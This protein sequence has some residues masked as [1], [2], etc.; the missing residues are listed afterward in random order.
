[1]PP[2]L[3][4]RIDRYRIL[5]FLGRGSMG[6]V[7]L[8]VD[9]KFD[10]RVAL[11][12]MSGH[13]LGEDDEL[14]D[15]RQRF[16][17][18][19]RAAGRLNHPA[20]VT[21]YDADT[22]R[23][24]G[25]PF[26]AMEWVDG[27]SLR[28][29]LRHQGPLGVTHTVEL[30]A[31]VASALSYAHGQGVVHR[32]IKPANLLLRSD[33]R[34]K[35][36][37]FGIAK[38]VS[39]A[40]TPT[41]QVLGSPNYM[42]P[43]QVKAEPV[44]GRTDLFALGVV[45]YEGL[46]GRPAFAAESLA[47][48]TFKIVSVDPRPVKMYN[49]RVPAELEAVLQR[50]LEKD[51]AARF[52]TGAEMAMALDAI[53]QKLDPAAGDPRPD[54]GPSL[55]APQRASS[56]DGSTVPF[57]RPDRRSRAGIFSRHG[58]ADDSASGSSGTPIPAA[59]DPEYLGSDTFHGRTRKRR[60]RP[61]LLAA[62]ALSVVASGLLWLATPA[63]PELEILT[64]R[65]GIFHAGEPVPPAAGETAEPVAGRP[66]SGLGG[67]GGAEH[68]EPG[69]SAGGVPG[70]AAGGDG[71]WTVPLEPDAVGNAQATQPGDAGNS[72]PDADGTHGIPTETLSTVPATDGVEIGGTETGRTDSD[73]TDPD[74]TAPDATDP[75]ATDPDAADS[76][77]TDP[78]ST[79]ADPT[80]SGAPGP[81]ATGPTGIDAGGTGT[82]APGLDAIPAGSDA[83]GTDSDAP[84]PDAI[85]ADSDASGTETGG[86]ETGGTETGGTETG[87]T[88]T[89]GTETEADPG[90]ETE[91]TE[92]EG[93][94]TEADPADSDAEGT[95]TADSGGHR[96]PGT[97][98]GPSLEQA[99]PRHLVR[100][101]AHLGPWPELLRASGALPSGRSLGA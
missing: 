3:P 39:S 29:L 9:P 83:G 99:A 26:I 49:P 36:A 101:T 75:D 70:S 23:E 62:L 48:I 2:E 38:L 5:D 59:R 96:T 24:T 28:H 54:H 50:A 7:Y 67:Q 69:D 53:A 100:G 32:D 93:T 74:A 27:S 80:A 15:L 55:S 73:A 4:A 33:G 1:M 8:A 57:G 22:D 71:I 88:E 37:D 18:E 40:L 92:T 98:R 47:S 81:G 56:T 91:G 43:E 51:P 77:T 76:G 64:R 78:D 90:T 95:G 68:E 6:E 97:D 41:G 35:V 79:D 66:P 46:A 14:E 45:L 17:H 86:T 31:R 94:E 12:V 25:W 11:K 52:Q 10:R 82:E 63:S 85:P 42:A 65:L 30:G 72:I 61:W 89:E 34:V 19:A 44:D 20:I 58:A 87:G 60:R 13:R 84:G 16:V 21:V